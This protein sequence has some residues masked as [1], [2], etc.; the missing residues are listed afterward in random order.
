MELCAN[1]HEE[2][3]FETRSCPLC[4]AQSETEELMKDA[5]SEIEEL[6]KKIDD[7]EDKIIELEEV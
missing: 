3:C 1:G 7:L 4:D 6:M 5:Q 2:I